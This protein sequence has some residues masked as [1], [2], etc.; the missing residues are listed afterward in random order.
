MVVVVGSLIALVFFAL[1]LL[2]LLV[3]FLLLLVL[4]ISSFFLSIF[5]TSPIYSSVVLSYRTNTGKERQKCFDLLD[6]LTKSGAL[7]I[8][9]A[10]LHIVIAATHC[11]DKSVM[12][13]LIQGAYPIQKN[14]HLNLQG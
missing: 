10:S 14:N 1:F 3:Y 7:P 4:F 2:L 8:D 12:N 13:T 11:F 9:Y 5:F 6:A